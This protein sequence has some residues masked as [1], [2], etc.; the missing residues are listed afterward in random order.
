MITAKNRLE[1]AIDSVLLKVMALDVEEYQKLDKI[2]DLT[3][4]EHFAYQEAQAH[5]F[6]AGI[7][8]LD[9]AQICY[10][11]LGEL[12]SKSNGGW[13]DGVTLEIKFV[14]TQT[15]TELLKARI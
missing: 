8:S 13:A 9:E 3:F 12:G 1:A 4:E 10:R 7:L 5:A 14:V 15:I 2:F 6:A 11:A